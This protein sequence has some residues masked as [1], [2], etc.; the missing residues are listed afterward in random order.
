[1]KNKTVLF[2]MVLVFI[3]LTFGGIQLLYGR[4]ECYGPSGMTNADD[5]C[6]RNSYLL[7]AHVL[8]GHCSPYHWGVCV[9]SYRIYC[10]NWNSGTL[11]IGTIKRE[12]TDKLCMQ[13]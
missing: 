13:L 7:Y 10:E 11:T 6:P 12:V 1:M 8:G 5:F 9:A 3:A 2:L 4:A